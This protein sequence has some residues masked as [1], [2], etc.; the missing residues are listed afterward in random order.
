MRRVITR[1]G[2]PALVSAIV[3]APVLAPSAA[4]AQTATYTPPAGVQCLSRAFVDATGTSRPLSIYV[5][6]GETTTYAAKGFVAGACT[7]MSLTAYRNESCRIAHMGNDAV[8]KRLTHL[9]GARPK[10]LCDSAL[11]AAPLPASAGG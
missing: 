3:L 10:D 5:P 9:L 11:R 8:Q 7:G 1:L 6:A 4:P 2:G